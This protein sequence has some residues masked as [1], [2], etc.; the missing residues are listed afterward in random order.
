M[1]AHLKHCLFI[2]GISFFLFNCDKDDPSPNIFTIQDD[3]DLGKQAAT[4][5]EADPE[6]PVLDK[7]KYP[8]AY[9]H[10]ERIRNNILNSGKVK[11]KDDFEWTVKII[12]KDVLNAFCLPGGY[13]DV[14]FSINNQHMA[15]DVGHKFL[16]EAVVFHFFN[17]FN[18]GTSSSNL[19]L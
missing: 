17:R 7:S 10:L 12:N 15:F 19:P 4:E 2:I 1:K 8:D 13:Q 6:Y 9:A 11:Y 5:I 16:R 18:E 3:I 14:S